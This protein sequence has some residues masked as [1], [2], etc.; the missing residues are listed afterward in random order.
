M[1]TPDGR[2]LRGEQ[3]AEPTQRG[4]PALRLQHCDRARAEQEWEVTAQGEVQW[5]RNGTCL[6]AL[7]GEKLVLRACDR[8]GIS[9]RWAWPEKKL[10]FE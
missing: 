1:L 4:D 9:Q 10:R 6:T 3:C 7:R 8:L 2:I 5:R